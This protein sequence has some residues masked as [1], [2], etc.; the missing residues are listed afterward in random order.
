MPP[1]LDVNFVQHLTNLRRMSSVSPV[2]RREAAMLMAQAVMKHVYAIAPTD[3]HRYKR[4][5]VLANNAAGLPTLPPPPITKAKWYDKI[6]M[7]LRKDLKRWEENEQYW[8]MIMKT[9]YEDKGRVF[10]KNRARSIM[11]GGAIRK[12]N[13]SKGGGK[14]Y[15]QLGKAGGVNYWYQDAVNKMMNAKR[16]AEQVRNELQKLISTPADAVIAFNFMSAGKDGRRLTVRN[17]IYGGDGR[18]VHD[19][20][21]AG[22]TVVVLH[23]KEAHASLVEWRFKTLRLAGAGFVR[24]L[25][26]RRVGAEYLRDVERA[27]EWRKGRG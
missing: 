8:R 6:E 27:V 14:S 22:S 18:V 4:A 2:A 15:R 9:R 26:L 17:L 19:P 3:T 23:N 5:W 12:S 1:T 24:E 7:A 10:Y 20:S 11:Q 13:Y 21:P 25:G 16:A